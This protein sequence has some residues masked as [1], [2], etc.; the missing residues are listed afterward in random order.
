[1]RI[2]SKTTIRMNHH[3]RYHGGGIRRV[4]SRVGSVHSPSRLV[5]DTVMSYL[6]GGGSCR[7]E[8]IGI[9]VSYTSFPERE[10]L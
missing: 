2:A 9:D 7:I 4:I 6:P 3:D 8:N 1:M 5:Q 10:N